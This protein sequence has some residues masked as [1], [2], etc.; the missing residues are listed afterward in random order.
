MAHVNPQPTPN[1]QAFKFT[2][3]GHTFDAPISI[4]DA[5]A[6]QGT[7]F[8]AV[9]KLPGVAGLFATANFVTVTKT[10]AS[11]WEHLVPL[12][13]ETLEQSF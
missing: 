10:Q 12:V 8:E 2:I 7:P 5:D 11:D 13:K 6:A 4:T 3:E 1:P 9:L